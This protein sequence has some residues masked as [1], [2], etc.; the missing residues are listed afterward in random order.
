MLVGLRE[1]P[2]GEGTFGSVND[3]M[4]DEGDHMAFKIESEGRLLSRVQGHEN[5][6]EFFGEF[7]NVREFCLDSTL[8][9]FCD[10]EQ[11]FMANTPSP[12]GQI[13]MHESQLT[14]GRVHIHSAGSSTPG[15]IRHTRVLGHRYRAHTVA[16]DIFSLG[17]VLY[18]MVTRRMP[19]LKTRVYKP[20]EDYPDDLLC[21]GRARIILYA[22]C[23][24]FRGN[25]NQQAA[26][27]VPP[28]AVAVTATH[29]PG[30][31]VRSSRSAKPVPSPALTPGGQGQKELLRHVRAVKVFK[32]KKVAREAEWATAERRILLEWE[33]LVTK[34]KAIR[35]LVALLGT[36]YDDIFL[37][38]RIK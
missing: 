8:H 3:V 26:I 23:K 32:G 6:V 20:E 31:V 17:I 28:V 7:D 38:P 35:E 1:E 22:W 12:E 4:D 18:N 16:L 15:S 2:V 25:L 5:V 9:E 19:H 30:P 29:A 24:F 21:S 33:H 13:K 34:E 11:L 37:R 14:A 27:T 10:I 36:N